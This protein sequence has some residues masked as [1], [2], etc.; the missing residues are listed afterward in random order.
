MAMSHDF[1]ALLYK[2]RFQPLKSLLIKAKEE[3]AKCPLIQSDL[4]KT[5]IFVNNILFIPDNYT[6]QYIM[7]GFYE[8]IISFVF[9]GITF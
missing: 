8:I 1:E 6:H 3:Y 9:D 4:C 5:Q 2:F 7:W